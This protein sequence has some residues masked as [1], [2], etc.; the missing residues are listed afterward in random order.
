MFSARLVAADVGVD[1]VTLAEFRGCRFILD[2]NVL[3]ALALE[4]HR[5]AKSLS[6]LGEALKTLGVE[7]CYIRPSK[8]EYERVASAQKAQVLAM[9]KNYRFDVLMDAVDA[10][11]STARQR[12]CT[13]VDD[14]ERFLNSVAGPP[15]CFYAE[16]DV[17]SLFEDEIVEEAIVSAE[18]DENL[19]E[20][21]KRASKETKPRWRKEKSELSVRHDACF[22]SVIERE[23]KEG[24][25]C[26]GMTL[27]RSLP[28]VANRLAGPHAYPTVIGIDCLIEILA[29]EQAGP[30]VD[31]TDYAPL[32]ANTI[33]NQAEPLPGTY[34]VADLSFVANVNDAVSALEEED[35]KDILREVARLR[36]GGG[37]AKV[38]TLQLTINRLLT[39]KRG[40]EQEELGA[41]RLREREAKAALEDEKQEASA[42]RG[43]VGELE[44]ETRRSKAAVKLTKRLLWRIPC[45]VGISV[46][47]FMVARV[48]VPDG[49]VEGFIAYGSGVLSFVLGVWKL[50]LTAIRDHQDERE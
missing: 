6:A 49:K 13:T 15:G 40:K 22:L 9:A 12:S 23:R 19:Q 43:R 36:M 4:G 48:A 17:L 20:E 8:E 3:F 27:D 35:T 33:L 21:I 26:W 31:A 11:V 14:L 1:P 38:Q 7:L 18:R 16:E 39:G 44:L 47:V 25:K 42:L 24:K 28:V 46:A 37:E 41:A 29:V 32:L 45:A 34:T 10:F 50:V 30:E 5:L 2:T